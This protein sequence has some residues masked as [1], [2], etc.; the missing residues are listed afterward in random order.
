[1]YG[2]SSKHQIATLGY[3][4][5][6]FQWGS[7]FLHSG[8]RNEFHVLHNNILKDYLQQIL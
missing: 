7:K 1:M 3:Q 2:I 6:R 8:I 5:E 4:R